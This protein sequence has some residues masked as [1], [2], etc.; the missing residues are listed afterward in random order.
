MGTHT[1][2]KPFACPQCEYRRKPALLG[3]CMTINIP[4]TME[5]HLILK[6]VMNLCLVL[7]YYI[8]YIKKLYIETKVLTE[9]IR[10]KNFPKTH[11][12]LHTGEKPSNCS[13][14]LLDNIYVHYIVYKSKILMKYDYKTVAKCKIVFK[15]LHNENIHSECPECEYRSSEKRKL[16]QC[17]ITN[18][19]YTQKGTCI[20]LC[21]IIL[22][23]VFCVESYFYYFQFP[24]TVSRPVVCVVIMHC[25]I[26]FLLLYSR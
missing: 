17:L 20:T 11:M 26:Y 18:T 1:E 6:I 22:H 2:E 12:Q 10:P 23:Y 7:Y 13:L 14:C 16:R 25:I 15:I 3:Q 21:V 4:L 5:L 24:I 9:I 8:A 19:T